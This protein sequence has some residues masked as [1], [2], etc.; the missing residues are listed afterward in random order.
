MIAA[1]AAR[2]GQDLRGRASIPVPSTPSR[3]SASVPPPNA[4]RGDGAR[5][6]RL[7]PRPPIEP[8]PAVVTRLVARLGPAPLLVA[9][10]VALASALSSVGNLSS[11]PMTRYLV[12]E[13]ILRDGDL[14]IEPSGLTVPGGPAPGDPEHG[15]H[16]SVFF[17]GQSIVMLPAAAVAE[18]ARLVL[19]GPD[20][21]WRAAGGFLTAAGIIP[22][23][24]GMAVLGHMALLRRVGVDE[25]TSCLAGLL[26][27][28]AT[29]HW[30]WASAAS[31]EVIVGALGTWAL[32]ACLDGRRRLEADP[33]DPAAAARAFGLA[34]LMMAGG[35]LHRG[36]FLP[37]I[38]AGAALALPAIVRAGPAIA[39]RLAGRLLPWF[40]ASVLVAGILPLYNWI[41]FDDPLETGY[42]RFYAELGGLWATPLLTGLRGHLLSPGKSIFLYTPVLL[43]ALPAL[44]SP[45]T[46]RRLAP[47]GFAVAVAVA[48]HLLIYSKTTYWA[49][50]FGW[51]VRFHVSMMPLMM[52]PIGAWLAGRP[53]WPRWG[54]GLVVAVIAAS[55]GVQ[56][57]GLSL[58]TGLETKQDRGAYA[59]DDH[60]LPEEA[61]WTWAHSPLKL[62]AL[63]VWAK[64]AGPGIEPPMDDPEAEIMTVWN[65]FPIRAGVAMHDKPWLVA[66]C[67]TA[68]SVLLVALLATLRALRR[69]WPSPAGADEGDTSG[70]DGPPATASGVSPSG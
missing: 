1:P 59:A 22:A 54:R 47:V 52:L 41:R 26:V 8:S 24:A 9:L 10:V 57:L 32:V 12:A 27:G 44:A 6:R 46:R 48:T 62:R 28:L 15:P 70:A 67:W 20:M 55:V 30:V 13:S 56:L 36:T 53:R 21:L 64:V 4:D 5:R 61:A 63:N 33:A 3:S 65:V 19:G 58:N 66:A 31:E 43:L 60:R 49:G 38:L 40:V 29:A 23:F 51:A 50:A 16:Y 7:S 39:G 14:A 69:R 37:F 11:D 42:G 35:V 25:R 2:T 68:W 18:L 17:P 45:A 34:G